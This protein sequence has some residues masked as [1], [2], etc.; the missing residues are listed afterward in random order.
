MTHSYTQMLAVA[1]DFSAVQEAFCRA[2][3]RGLRVTGGEV[4]YSDRDL[5]TG[6]LFAVVSFDA[7]RIR[8]YRITLTEEGVS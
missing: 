6:D 5:D 4:L 1:D 7:G 8:T 2:L 3:G